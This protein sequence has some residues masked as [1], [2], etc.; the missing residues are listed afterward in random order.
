MINL[1]ELTA[2]VMKMKVQDEL[3]EMKRESA[4]APKL[5]KTP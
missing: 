4:S 3:A 1:K 2:T 5:V